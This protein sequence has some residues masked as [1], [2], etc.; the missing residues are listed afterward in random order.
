MQR[1]QLVGPIVPIAGQQLYVRPVDT[2]KQA[3]TI[4]FDFVQPVRVIFWRA[5]DQ[6]RELGRK[7]FRQGRLDNAGG[8]LGGGRLVCKR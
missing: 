8:Q 4:E 2:R 6:R 5:I 3:V 1:Q 7:F